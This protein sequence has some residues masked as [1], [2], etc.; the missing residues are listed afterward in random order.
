MMLVADSRDDITVTSRHV[1]SGE[2][3]D[4]PSGEEYAWKDL[5]VSGKYHNY[6]VTRIYGSLRLK[7]GGKV[8]L[9]ANSVMRFVR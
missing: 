2:I 5:A 9:G 7:A 6:G 1:Q 8:R 3:V 4:I